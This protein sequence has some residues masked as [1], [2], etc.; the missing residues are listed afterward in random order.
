MTSPA[1]ALAISSFSPDC[2]LR[3]ARTKRSASQILAWSSA[4]R[5]G[6]NDLGGGQGFEAAPRQPHIEPATAASTCTL[7]LG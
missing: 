3:L 1:L 2:P 5:V 7:S 4:A 6:L